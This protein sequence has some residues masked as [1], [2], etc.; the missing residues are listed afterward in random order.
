MRTRLPS[1]KTVV[2]DAELRAR[3]QL[4]KEKQKK[5]KD[6]K[7]NVRPHHIRVGDKV[8]LL[9]KES[10]TKSRYEPDPYQVTVVQGT[11]ITAVRGNKIRRRDAKKFKKIDIREQRNYRDAREPLDLHRGDQADFS[12]TDSDSEE[13]AGATAAALVHQPRGQRPETHMANPVQ[14]RPEARHHRYP[15]GVLDPHVDI[16]LNRGQRNR[17]QRQVYNA[18]T[19]GWN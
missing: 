18:S 4:A 3:N 15:N 5:Y 13:T 12:I 19:G 6:A 1:R 16:T 7:A 2:E 11:Q 8:L 14:R 9:Q 10:K 17:G